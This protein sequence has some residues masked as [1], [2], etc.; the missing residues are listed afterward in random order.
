MKWHERRGQTIDLSIAA[1]VAVLI[2]SLFVLL[3]VAGARAYAGS[4]LTIDVPPQAV[5]GVHDGD[6]FTVFNLLPPGY[7]SIRVKG[8]DAPE[9][10]RKKGVPDEPGAEEAQRFTARWLAEDTFRVS[11]CGKY[12]FERIEAVVERNGI[13]LAASLIEAGHWKKQIKPKKKA[14]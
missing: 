8:V 13:S 10:S 3:I 1:I 4:C 6:T 2:V 7:V 5:L 14:S 9:F 11:T 12:T